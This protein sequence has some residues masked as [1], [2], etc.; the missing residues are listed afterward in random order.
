V[1]SGGERALQNRLF[2][3]TKLPTSL[4]RALDVRY[5]LRFDARERA[6]LERTALQQIAVFIPEGAVASGADAGILLRHLGDGWIT[7]ADSLIGIPIRWPAAPY[8]DILPLTVEKTGKDGW[9]KIDGDVPKFIDRFFRRLGRSKESLTDHWSA[10]YPMMGTYEVLIPEA[11][12]KN[13][14]LEYKIVL[15]GCSVQ[16][17]AAAARKKDAK[18]VPPGGK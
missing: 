1:P 5:P 12:A 14:R 6:N 2:L 15:R 13:P 3:E 10:F 11:V 16:N 8:E 9:E 18:A 4:L 17:A 7:T